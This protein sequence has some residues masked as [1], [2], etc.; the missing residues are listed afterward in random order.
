MHSV[1][2]SYSSKEMDEAEFVRDILEL[3]GIICW[4]A[5]RDIPAGANY[6]KVIPKAIRDCKVF[7]L[8][9]S[10]NAQNSQFVPRELDNAVTE[11]KTIVPFMLEDCPINE[12]FNFLLTGTQRIAAYQRKAE[13]LE[14]L[15]RQIWALTGM[16]SDRDV[17]V[18]RPEVD[19][20][21]PKPPR[22]TLSQKIKRLMKSKKAMTIILAVVLITFLACFLPL[23]NAI[24]KWFEADEK[25]YADERAQVAAIGYAEEFLYTSDY[26][27][28]VL[29]DTIESARTALNACEGEDSIAEDFDVDPYREDL[30]NHVFLLE[31]LISSSDA[32]YI[33]QSEYDPEFAIEIHKNVLTFYSD[34][35][36]FLS[37]IDDILRIHD[38][39][40]VENKLLMLEYVEAY[41]DSV[42]KLIA[43]QT[44]SFLLPLAEED[45][46]K[47]IFHE[48][49][50]QLRDYP[51][52][53]ETWS[54]DSGELSEKIKECTAELDSLQRLLSDDEA[55]LEAIGAESTQ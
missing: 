41:A 1:F 4:M 17:I 26:I 54:Y 50:P 21:N 14:G 29:T 47:E 10:E 33:Y 2:I 53:E 12:E 15:V 27:R 43:L 3:N 7:V 20:S 5:P 22:K 34:S 55:L 38:E 13:V 32:E 25:R 45:L 42:T 31:Y 39:L 48:V 28:L 51:L 6:A 52:T 37:S 16:D 9:L 46:K 8:I 49:F 24:E 36:I 18:E 44:N 30:F 11:R 40:T 19:Y 35:K 23:V